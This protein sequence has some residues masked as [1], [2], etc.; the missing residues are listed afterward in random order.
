MLA[1]IV[2]PADVC[3]INVTTQHMLT[4]RH[5]AL[6]CCSVRHWSS[7]GRP[8]WSLQSSRYIQR[9]A[10]AMHTVCAL[11]TTIQMVPGEL[12]G[13]QASRAGVLPFGQS[14]ASSCQSKVATCADVTERSGFILVQVFA[15]PLVAWS[16]HDRY[17]L[18]RSCTAS[19]MAVET[20]ITDSH[21]CSLCYR[22]CKGRCCNVSNGCQAQNAYT[23]PL[24]DSSCSCRPI[25][26]W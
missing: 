16:L 17:Q 2:K 8:L 20:K 25:T 10:A 18:L 26:V 21:M 23:A 9:A 3:Y 6:S 7:F 24:Q 14:S 1:S 22:G 19:D 5:P 12:S 15:C 11:F 13:V 4:Y